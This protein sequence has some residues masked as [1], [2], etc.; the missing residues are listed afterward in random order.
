MRNYLV[1]LALF[2]ITITQAQIMLPAYQSI[3][4]RRNKVLPSITTGVVTCITSINAACGGTI[5]NDGGDTVTVSGICWNTSSGPTIA[6]NTKTTNGTAI[7]SFIS[8]L[9]LLTPNTTYYVKA[10]ATNSI[11]TAYGN[12]IT[13]TTTAAQ[14]SEITIGT[15]VWASENLTVTT[16]RDGTP[17]P[18]VTNPSA[19]LA[20]PTGA[21][22]YYNNDPINGI[23]Y[24]KLYNWYA[25]AGIYDTASLNN[26]LLR[27]QLAPMGWHIPTNAEYTTL[28]NFLGGTNI[29]GGKMKATCTTLWRNPNSGATNSSG[30]TALGGGMLESGAQV[31]QQL[32]VGGQ[33]WCSNSASNPQLT[34]CCADW[35]RLGH[36]LTSAIVSTQNKVNFISVRCLKD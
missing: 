1:I 6:L 15:Q 10:Y 22:C 12:E 14:P 25:V 5:T 13:F 28:I 3:Q 23:I 27:K 18:Q 30:F 26:P 29:A 31:F 32:Q 2:F 24:G 9:L 33:F 8:N 11:G 21:W 34:A 35:L 17:I 4:Y 20:S 36:E 19:L 16:Y 7:G